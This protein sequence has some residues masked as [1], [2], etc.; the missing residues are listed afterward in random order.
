MCGIAGIVEKGT[1]SRDLMN[2][3]LS[4]IAHRGPDASSQYT[5]GNITLGHRRL[6]IIDL[7]TGDQPMFNED[8]SLC[9]IFN[10]EIYNYQDLKSELLK[11]GHRFTT[12][13][14]TEVLLHGYE[15]YGTGLFAKLNGIF[16]FVILQL[17]DNKLILV[18][19][20][21]GIKPLHYYAK[22]DLFI[23][24]SEQK[25]ILLH[26]KVERKFNFNSLH[27]HINLRYTQRDETL[28]D[29]I[30]RL[31]PAHFLV[32]NEGQISLEKYWSLQPQINYDIKEDDAVDGI[33]HYIKQAVERQ[34][35]SDVPLG[36]YLSGGMDSS[37]IVQKMSELGVGKINTFTMGFN[38]PTDEFP[39]SEL[40]ARTFNTNHKTLS[41]PME[42]LLNLPE[43]IWH[44][45]EPKI[46]LLQGFNMSKF[47]SSDIKVV[48]G[49][50]GGDELFAGYD[51]HKFIYPFNKWHN[52]IP[53]WLKTLMTWK[54][55][56]IFT[57]QNSTK[58]L[59]LDEYRRG[60]Q[61]LLSIGQI[62]KFYLILRNVWDFD[63]GFYKNIYHPSFYNIML[64]E[65]QKVKEQFLPY[66]EKSKS[67]S[68]LDKVLYT[69]FHTK[70]VNDYLLVEDRM[71][72]SHSVEERVPFLD[73]DLVEFAF[74][75]PVHLKIK[76]NQS[77]YL[78]RKA[79]QGKLPD[80]ILNKK[81]WGFTVNPYLQFKKDLKKNAENILT[82]EFLDRQGIF[83]H[84]YIKQIL[85]YP[86]SPRLRW[87]YN[88]LWVVM[89]M[90]ILEKM[91]ISSSKM[92]ER[93]FDLQEYFD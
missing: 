81:K 90:A 89:G 64:T 49:G 27:S 47:V 51:I 69:E 84:D 73:K 82:K 60:A 52:N 3:M 18:R 39:D 87:H 83:N 16:A 80:K 74:S 45:E 55:D 21:F 70:M 85:N 5:H 67:L 71:S 26:E 11:K 19:D 65:T 62:E 66:F 34:L 10:G 12:N 22:E 78:F 48:L 30:K 13:A 33:N 1:D 50:L 15:E 31:P 92:E 63:N 35:M 40:I 2:R 38:E 9:V 44:A 61:M 43:V 23:F 28:F 93:R 91:F 88:Y 36:V 59:K 68:D 8:K 6:S 4:V 76:N 53:D 54:S 79:L 24:S 25:A 58:T 75:I 72:M 17:N 46:N 42:P 14:D 77:K 37:T 41:L 57:F 29:G 56:F 7:F 86:P 20:N 32:Y